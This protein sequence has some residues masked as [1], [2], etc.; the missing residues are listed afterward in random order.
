MRKLESSVFQNART[1]SIDNGPAAVLVLHGWTGWTGRLAPLAERLGTAGFSVRLPRLPGHG[2]SL[3]DFLTTTWRDWVRRA[4]DEYIDLHDHYETVYVAGTSMGALL[5]I[6]IG[7]RFAPPAIAL[8]AP[9][10]EMKNSFVFLAPVVKYFVPRIGCDWDP[11]R[12]PDPEAGPIGKEYKSYNYPRA[13]AELYHIRQAARRALPR[14]YSDT[15]AISSTADETVPSTVLDRIQK[16]VPAENVK[17]LLLEKSGH[18]MVQGVEGD[19]VCQ[20]VVDWFS[21]RR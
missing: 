14:L 7:A 2:T 11:S 9:A 21:D 16:R 20:A 4:Y 8:L 15:L 6:L 19:V 1:L 3:E 10:L 13:I 12:D 5:A 17:T 18:Q